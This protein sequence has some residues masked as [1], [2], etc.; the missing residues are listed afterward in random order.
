MAKK[1]EKTN[2]NEI[3]VTIEGESWTKALDKAFEKKNKEVTIPG[4]RKGK[5]PRNVFEKKY[6]KESLYNI[7]RIYYIPRRK[8]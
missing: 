3:K 5:A 8:C 7:R 2:K 6:G 1:S 4:F